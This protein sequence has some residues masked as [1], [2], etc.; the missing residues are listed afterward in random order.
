LLPSGSP[1]L[2]SLLLFAD[3]CRP[4]QRITTPGRTQEI[5]ATRKSKK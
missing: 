4:W 1:F 3:S 5:R 2:S